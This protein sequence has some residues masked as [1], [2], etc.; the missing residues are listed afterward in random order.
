MRLIG[1]SCIVGSLVLSVSIAGAEPPVL[2]VSDTLI[3]PGQSVRLTV[4]GQPG[5][6]FALATSAFNSGAMVS[7][8]PLDLGSD[9]AIITSGSLDGTGRAVVIFTPPFT[10]SSGVRAYFQ[11]AVSPSSSFAP[12]F[13]SGGVSV[14]NLQQTAIG[15]A[16]GPPGPV[17]PAG[18]QGVPGAVGP[19]GPVGAVGPLGPAGAQGLAGPAGAPGPQGAAGPVGPIGATGAVGPVGP[20]GAPG[21][22]GAVGPVGPTGLRGVAGPI[23]PT[24]LT[25]AVGPIGATG[26]SGPAGPIGAT[27]PSGAVGPIGATGPAG[28]AGPAGAAGAPGAQGAR[29]PAGVVATNG[30]GAY[31]LTNDNGFVSPGTLGRGSL[32]ASGAGARLVWAPHKA[33]FRAGEVDD[34]QWD[35]SNIGPYSV[36]TGLG[37]QAIGEASMSM[38]AYNNASAYASTALGENNSAGGSSSFAAG[39]GS[40][41]SGTGAVAVGFSHIVLGDFGFAAGSGGQVY[42]EAAI[43]LGYGN[44]AG[45]AYSVVTGYYGSD[46]DFGGTFVFSDASSGSLFRSTNY[47]E[48][49]ARASGGVRFYTSSGLTAGVRL[50]PGDSAWS[51]VSDVNMKENFRDLAG[52]DILSKL[53]RMPIREWNYKAQDASIRHAGPTAQDFHSAFGL[54]SDP[55]RISTIDADGIALAGVQALES[56]TRAMNEELAAL[57][58]ELA[59]LRGELAKR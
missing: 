51:S 46:N 24:G 5:Y 13:F 20:V 38:G 4:H 55:L 27:G 16:Q 35:D 29:G 50:A 32:G 9:Y 11:V 39:Y 10:S 54:G 59:R 40:T 48:F 57:R 22:T 12:T 3:A 49:A 42:S 34:T 23:G 41:A 36:A 19:Q 33:A 56:R 1:Y 30:A 6:F 21:P 52:E 47:N 44:Y 7:G 14:R 26:P 25:G 2:T 43:T 58:L 37:S 15:G 8:I 18:P 53:S 17:G 45:G 28:P 31:D